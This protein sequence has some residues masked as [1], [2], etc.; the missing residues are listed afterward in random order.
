[1]LNLEGIQTRYEDPNPILDQIAL[2]GKDDFVGLMQTLYAEPI[3][4]EL[5][6]KRIQAIKAGGGLPR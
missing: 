3:K 1:V 6:T 4:P 2:V 5:I